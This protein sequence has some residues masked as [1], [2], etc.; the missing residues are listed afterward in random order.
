MPNVG[1]LHQVRAWPRPVLVA[2]ARGVFRHRLAVEL[3]TSRFASDRFGPP[4]AVPTLHQDLRI[5]LHAGAP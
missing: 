1:R 5:I 2:P 3:P 4:V